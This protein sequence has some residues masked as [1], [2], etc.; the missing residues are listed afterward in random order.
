M[1]ALGVGQAEEEHPSSMMLS[2]LC[3]QVSPPSHSR[4]TWAS[5]AGL[6]AA[7][8]HGQYVSMLTLNWE[9]GHC[10][11][12]KAEASLD[13]REVD[14]AH[15]HPQTQKR[16]SHYNKHSIMGKAI[17]TL[18][19]IARR[20]CRFLG[21]NLSQPHSGDSKALSRAYPPK[22]WPVLPGRP[23]PPITAW[24]LALF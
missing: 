19:E 6:K 7:G 17:Y 15:C 20:T 24:L 10:V 18:G 16:D 9:A 14:S 21:F 8:S 5:S 13:S 4:G 12:Q 22:A 3:C 23:D 2:G 11:T 1:K